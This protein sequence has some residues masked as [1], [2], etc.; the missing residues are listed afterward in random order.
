MNIINRIEQNVNNVKGLKAALTEYAAENPWINPIP[1]H[2]RDG[3][4]PA[5]KGVGSLS[6]LIQGVSLDELNG[7][8][9]LCL[10]TI[11]K[12]QI[13]IDIDSP[14]A[15][16]TL[17]ELQVTCN[18][19]DLPPTYTV[20][21]AEGREAR[22]YTFHNTGSVIDL[23]VKDA[24]GQYPNW[25]KLEFRT[26]NAY[27]IVAGKHPSGA[28]YRIVDD[29]PPVPFPQ[30]WIAALGGFKRWA[31]NKVKTEKAETNTQNPVPNMSKLN[32]L[33]NGNGH[34]EQN[35]NGNGHNGH[36]EYKREQARHKEHK[37]HKG[38]VNAQLAAILHAIEVIREHN[39]IYLEDNHEGRI[40][41]GMILH[42]VSPDE[43]GFE[44]WCDYAD[45]IG[46]NLKEKG[47][48]G[49]NRLQGFRDSWK[50][51]K[52]GGGLSAKSVTYWL[53]AATEGAEPEAI[54][55]INNAIAIVREH[56]SDT[57]IELNEYIQIA[58]T[59]GLT[60]IQRES[61]VLALCKEHG[62]YNKNEEIHDRIDALIEKLQSDKERY[63]DIVGK[64]ETLNKTIFDYSAIAS[65]PVIKAVEDL[66][67]LHG[68]RGLQAHKLILALIGIYS[69]T[70]G[71]NILF[72][73]N[74][75]DHYPHLFLNF[76]ANA[77]GGKSVYVN[78]FISILE[79]WQAEA[80]IQNNQLAV[81]Y[82]KKRQSFITTINGATKQ[83]KKDKD[84]EDH[85]TIPTGSIPERLRMVLDDL[86]IEYERKTE[87]TTE[88]ITTLELAVVNKQFPPF[89]YKHEWG[90]FGEA[91]L[92][93]I[94]EKSGMMRKQGLVI[95]PDEIGALLDYQSNISSGDNE[96]SYVRMWNAK[97]AT[98]TRASMTTQHHSHYQTSIIG[99]LQTGHLDVYYD[100]KRDI[101]GLIS[102]ILWVDQSDPV[103][104]DEVDE[105]IADEVYDRFNSELEALYKTAERTAELTKGDEKTRIKPTPEAKKLWQYYYGKTYATAQDN[106]DKQTVYATWKS[107]SQEQCARIALTLHCLKYGTAAITTQIQT[108]IVALAIEIMDYFDIC[109]Q[110]LFNGGVDVDQIAEDLYQGDAK[111]D[112]NRVEWFYKICKKVRKNGG[113]YKFVK[114][115]KFFF[116]ERSESMFTTFGLND[117]RKTLGNDGFT[118]IANEMEEA[119]LITFN[120]MTMTIKL[121][122]GET[123]AKLE[124]LQELTMEQKEKTT[125]KE[126][127][128]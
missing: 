92:Q 124:A 13:A 100:A 30:D 123:T 117:G 105:S 108:D 61:D 11:L 75:H 94:R 128:K 12:G 110:N 36:K 34:K 15:Y 104:F 70:I 55:E 81:M 19:S 119:G 113:S 7:Y 2:H 40:K 23:R 87:Y 29:R 39:P 97:P 25:S 89:N 95:A 20:S 18:L 10:G 43:K 1:C 26:G 114:N 57:R 27:Q 68:T 67:R 65:V 74:K 93:G 58:G 48:N 45:I 4:K 86:H 102:R 28:I 51:F 79:K 24:H 80:E 47:T 14:E 88:E 76:I 121:K 85:V 77:A 111:V 106:A 31:E 38:D 46:Y 16:Q 35:G 115:D 96:R 118:T 5:C 82:E 17:Q 72:T 62:A 90:I 6:N 120:S 125:D 63:A 66:S 37:E 101:S 78:P 9:Y 84:D 99:T 8:S 44:A 41:V 107:R 109:F 69:G 49:S 98:S 3:K 56:F 59:L 32:E 71:K 122:N 103:F 83:K 42:S 127:T 91:T 112:S 73:V 53:K 64:A 22:I 54:R 50:S 21:S 33:M 60:R 126:N 116:K 52:V